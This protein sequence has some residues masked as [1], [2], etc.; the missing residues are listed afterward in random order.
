MKRSDPQYS[1]YHTKE[2]MEER[3]GYEDLSQFDYED[4]CASC[5]GA[6]AKELNIESTPKGLQFTYKI[7][8]RTMVIIAVYQSWKKQVSTVLPLKHF[9]SHPSVK[10]FL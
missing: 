10:H 5:R 9:S 2:R 7:E 6:F 8:F 4:L 1:Y 3:Y